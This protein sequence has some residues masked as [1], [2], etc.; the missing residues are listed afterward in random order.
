MYYQEQL[1][2]ESL[3]IFG[4]AAIALAADSTISSGVK[5]K[6]LITASFSL[7]S[8]LGNEFVEGNE[9]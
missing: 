3:G 9:F 7:Y 1:W 5:D 6:F 4:W 8:Q 2:S